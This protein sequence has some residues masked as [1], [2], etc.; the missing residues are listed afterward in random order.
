MRQLVRSAVVMSVGLFGAGALAQSAGQ[1]GQAGGW[2]PALGHDHRRGGEPGTAAGEM[3]AMIDP[4]AVGSTLGVYYFKQWVP[5]LGDW[6]RVAVYDGG[7]GRRELL[8]EVLKDLGMDKAE[9]AS[10]P[11]R[12]WTYIAVPEA[13]RSDAGVRALIKRL[14]ADDRVGFVSPVMMDVADQPVL[15]MPV[16]FVRRGP[17][18]N[19]GD[20][21]AVLAGLGV[22]REAGLNGWTLERLHRLEATT[23]NGLEL[24]EA[25]GALTNMDMFEFAETDR[26]ITY[27]HDYVPGDPLFGSSWHML[28]TGQSGGLGGFDLN[29]TPAWDVSLGSNAITT[30]IF[31]TGTQQ[32]HPDLN[33]IPGGDFTGENFPGGGAANVCERH[34]TAVMG[35]VVGITDNALGSVGAAPLSVAASARIGVTPVASPCGGTFSSSTTWVGNGLNSAMTNGYRVTN[36]SY[37]GGSNSATLAAIYAQTRQ[38]GLIHFASAGNSAGGATRWPANYAA[39]LCVSATNRFGNIAGFSTTGLEVDFS[40]PGEAI[41]TTDR[42]GNDGYGAGDSVSINGT[43]FSS[44]LSAGVAA[45]VL[46]VRPDL[47]GPQV[48]QIMRLTARDN[49][50][51]GYD[52]TFGYGMPDAS[53]AV[54]MAQAM[55]IPS[56]GACVNWAS[57]AAGG[58]GARLN[59]TAAFSEAQNAVIVHGGQVGGT[60]SSETWR[61]NSGGWTLLTSG[62]PAVADAGMAYDPV[63]REVVLA[64]GTLAGGSPSAN[65]WVFNGTTWTSFDAAHPGCNAGRLGYDPTRRQMIGLIRDGSNTLLTLARS[66]ATGLWSLLPNPG[67]IAPNNYAVAFDERRDTLVL[68]VETADFSLSVFELSMGTNTW[69]N[70]SYPGVMP[71]VL[72]GAYYDRA[73]QSTMIVTSDNLRTLAY[74]GTAAISTVGPVFVGGETSTRVASAYDAVRQ[75]GVLLGSQGAGNRAYQTQASSTLAVVTS[76]ASQSIATGQTLALSVSVS[77]TASGATYSWRRNGTPLVDGGTTSGAASP[78]LTITGITPAQAGTYD[79]VITGPCN[80]VTSDAAT[81]TVTEPSAIDLG[82][83]TDAGSP[84]SRSVTLSAGQVQWYRFTLA[85]AI[86]LSANTF[87]DIDSEG[88]N[89]ITGAEGND[90]EIGLYSSVGALIATDDDDGSGLNSQ[91]SFGRGTRPAVGDGSAYDGRDGATLTAGT[92]YLAI[93][94]YDSIFNATDFGVTSSSTRTGPAVINLRRGVQASSTVFNET[95][96]NDAKAAA[97]AFSM[98]TGNSIVGTSTSNTG[99]G[100]DTFRITTPGTGGLVRHRLLLSSTITGQSLTLRGLSQTAPGVISTTSDVTLATAP[101]SRTLQWYGLGTGNASVFVRVT[102]TASTT[103]PYSLLLDST[104]QTPADLPGGTLRSGSITLTSVGTTGASQIDTEFILLDS[105]FLPIAGYHNDDTPGTPVNRGS[106]LTRTFAPG[107]YYLATSNFNTAT[108]L[109]Q[110]NPDEGTPDGSVVDFPNVL[111]NSSS[112]TG[113]NV[114]LTVTDGAGPRAVALTKAG[115]FDV[116]VLR[117]VVAAPASCSPADIADTDGNPGG[118]NAIDN[119]D[120]TLFFGAFFADTSDPLRANADIADTDGNPGGDGAVDNGDFTLFFGAFFV[121]CP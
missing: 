63:R 38:N 29:I 14:S 112:T 59:A 94:G 50:A 56:P 53:A 73:R 20:A 40:A 48:E 90:A 103:S 21:R 45:L 72:A 25:A 70:L 43:S 55:T 80:S 66:S 8:G 58:P 101:A 23:N 100:I 97:N 121:G 42:T 62:G 39:V 107:T 44:P 34:G 24:L 108:N 114:S 46:S 117:M 113:V 6:S 82:T 7:K 36:H 3:P 13:E 93:A 74:D 17:T 110:A 104:P 19:E 27:T 68:I 11:A 31:D 96:P 60:P 22:A 84:V 49:G 91:L 106:T 4:R 57:A 87:L 99:A 109:S 16:M 51:T 26:L 41:I 5:M 54:A 77:G 83:L 65:T 118:D 12:G 61:L 115:A 71:G 2:T 9:L 86:D 116:L 1:I 98:A 33:Q 120:F 15:V 81:I 76:P 119:G 89:L 105:N 28:N 67:V 78:T 18:V 79:C 30:V 95:E 69:Q 35:C 88:S 85:T 32:D 75:V 92:Y 47:T 10:G 64:S 111:A 37:G 102:G 52:T